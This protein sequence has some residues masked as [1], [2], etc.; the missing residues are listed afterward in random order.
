[1]QSSLFWTVVLV[2]TWPATQGLNLQADNVCRL[3]TYIPFT[4]LREGPG[5]DHQN[6]GQY[7]YGNWPDAQALADSSISLVAVA[8]MAQRHFVRDTVTLP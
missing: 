7:G 5:G 4:D 1:M 3:L 6:P 2:A 8:E